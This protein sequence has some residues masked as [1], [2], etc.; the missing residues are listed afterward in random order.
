MGM[1]SD[2]T[3]TL[4]STQRQGTTESPAVT[5]RIPVSCGRKPPEGAVIGSNC[6]T[7]RWVIFVPAGH[8]F[9]LS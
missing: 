3:G 4:P 9:R 1:P 7:R 6:R 5:T 8:G 2:S